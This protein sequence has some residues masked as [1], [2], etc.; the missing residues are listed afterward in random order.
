MLYKAADTLMNSLANALV[1]IWKSSIGKKL[2][3]AIT[4]AMLVVFLV[5]HM[6]GNLLIFQGREDLNSYA[7]FLHHMLH[8]WGVWFARIGLL[9]AFGVHIAAT[10]SL[11]RQN[12]E[13]RQSRYEFEET[14]VAS[15]SSRIMIWSGL[16]VLA[17]V[18]FHILHFTVRVDSDLAGM[19]ET[20]DGVERHDVYGMV[21]EGFQNLFVVLFYIVGI[22]L[23]CS[24]LSHGIASLFQ[25]L[26]LRSDET[27]DAEKK[28]GLAVAVVLWL[29]FLSIPLSIGLGLKRDTDGP[30]ATGTPPPISATEG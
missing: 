23:L 2:I 12:R 1:Q 5:G 19:K 10:V 26:G 7:A 17:F 29:G 11:A 18:V 4:G 20:V 25:T 22:T 21:I 14:S 16:T 6:A 13:A 3:V 24:H 28:L 15:R 9:A 30:A 27:R 8:G